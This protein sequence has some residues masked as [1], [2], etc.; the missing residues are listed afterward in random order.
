[1]FVPCILSALSVKTWYQSMRMLFSL[2]KKKTFGQ[3]AKPLT[4]RQKCTM[5]NFSFMSSH[6]CI[7]GEHSQLGRVHTPALPVDLVGEDERGDDE[8]AT[9]VASSQAPSQL[10]SS[11][12]AG[13]SHPPPCDRRPPRG[14]PG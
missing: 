3:A 9:S 11:S 5:A 12:Q 7:R 14:P 4:T 6:L 13:P 8:D 1:M 10:P 2:L